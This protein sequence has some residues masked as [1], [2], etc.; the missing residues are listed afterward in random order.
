MG[1]SGRHSKASGFQGAWAAGSDN[2]VVTKSTAEL[3]LGQ[4]ELIKR[5]SAT[6]THH[7]P[8][9]QDPTASEL[10]SLSAP[11]PKQSDCRALRS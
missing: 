5:S 3:G 9:T 10:H 1:D 4:L 2:D 7:S 8:L 11:Q 6:D